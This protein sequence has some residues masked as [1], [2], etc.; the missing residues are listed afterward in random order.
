MLSISFYAKDGNPPKSIRVVDDFYEWLAKSDFSKV[1]QSEKTD[2]EIDGEIIEL[3]VVTL[4]NSNRRNLISF[5]SSTIQDETAALLK[6]LDAES[7]S[8]VSTRTYRL[9]KMLE[10]VDCLKS[11]S[12]QYLQ[13]E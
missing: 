5:F 9:R 10:L 11:E 8:S 2:L 1:G 7:E 4:G 12:Y 13:R 6:H 3:P